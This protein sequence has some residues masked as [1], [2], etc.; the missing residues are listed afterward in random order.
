MLTRGVSISG[1]LAVE[2]GSGHPL[3]NVEWITNINGGC[4]TAVVQSIMDDTGIGWAVDSV[5]GDVYGVVWV[6]VLRNDRGRSRMVASSVG[7]M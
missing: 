4:C 7:M 6:Q 1:S 3:G 5:M 2:A